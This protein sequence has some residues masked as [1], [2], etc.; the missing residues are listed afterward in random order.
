MLKALKGR[1]G[2]RPRKAG[3][4][5]RDLEEFILCILGLFS[6]LVELVAKRCLKTSL[7]KVLTPSENL[8]VRVVCLNRML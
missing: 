3:T 7:Y 2:A 4:V 8:F 1:L 5:S 6:Q